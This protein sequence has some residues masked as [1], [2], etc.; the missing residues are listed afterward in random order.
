MAVSQEYRD[1]LIEID[2]LKAERDAAR[3]D[4]RD[5]EQEVLERN[6]RISR[7]RDMLQGTQYERNASEEV[8]CRGCG[9]YDDEPCEAD[10]Q[11]YVLLR[12]L[13]A[14]LEGKPVAAET[15][16][17]LDE[18][19]EL[20]REIVAAKR[21]DVGFYVWHPLIDKAAQLLSREE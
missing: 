19:V 10:C 16:A 3:R 4:K 8:R 18:A 7:C 13:D 21:D 17:L 11:W 15:R 1:A 9:N 6:T 20:L 5:C 14:L 12:D 2:K